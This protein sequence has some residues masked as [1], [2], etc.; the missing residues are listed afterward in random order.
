[1]KIF[2]IILIIFFKLTNS[3]YSSIQ[4]NII[5]NFSQTNNFTFNFKQTV[6]GKDELGK[7]VIAYP[8]KIYCKYDMRYNKTLVSDGKN[9]VVK[10]D[11]NNQYYL[12]PLKKTPFNAILNKEY[13]INQMKNSKGILVDN[14][15]YKFQIIKDNYEINIFFDIESLKIVGWQTEDIYKNLVVTYIH[16][17]KYNVKIDNKIFVLPENN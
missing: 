7:C 2:I 6:N 16:D 11:K 12:Y 8:K 1:M 13:L 17:I 10:S 14:K 4:D 9:L 3:S 15:Y 5:K